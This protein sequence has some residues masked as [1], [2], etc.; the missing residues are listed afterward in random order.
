M[1]LNV[2]KEV[3]SE[4][5]FQERLDTTRERID[6]IEV[7]VRSRALQGALLTSYATILQSL[8]RTRELTLKDPPDAENVF[9]IMLAPTPKKNGWFR[10]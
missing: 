4:E 10:E 9:K 3:V 8:H 1:L 7:S 6:A 5:G 2:F